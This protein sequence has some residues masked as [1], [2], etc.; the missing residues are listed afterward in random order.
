MQY[1]VPQDVQREDTII[2]PITLK[3]LIILGIGG[4]IAY[5]IYVSLATTYFIEIWLPPVGLVTALTLAFAFLKIHNLPFHVFLMNFIEYHVLPRKRI[6]VQ[7]T[8]TPFI[9]SIQKEM[10]KRAAEAR[11][12]KEQKST[13]S[14]EELTKVLDTYGEKELPKDEK[15]E[16]LKKLINQ[17]YK[18]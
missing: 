3:Q 7:E 5:G 1:K 4:G 13:K 16:E 2:G 14:I 9:S 12:E 11:P 10:D 18:E 17:N 8:G 6:W 15:H